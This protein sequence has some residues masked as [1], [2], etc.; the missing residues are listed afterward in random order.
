ME[1][2]SVFHKNYEQITTTLI[3]H[4]TQLSIKAK[5]V[6]KM[7]KETSKRAKISREE[8]LFFAHV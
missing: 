1:I 8:T 6:E 3:L 2:I 5:T 7:K 4:Q